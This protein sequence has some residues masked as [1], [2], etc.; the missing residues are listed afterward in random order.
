M[1]HILLVLLQ[2]HIAMNFLALGI[3][4]YVIFTKWVF[5]NLKFHTPVF[6]T[7][8]TLKY[9][10]GS[11]IFHRGFSILSTQDVHNMIGT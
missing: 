2:E 7:M 9:F 11:G 3:I 8:L 6:W 4:G 10:L 1:K 5:N